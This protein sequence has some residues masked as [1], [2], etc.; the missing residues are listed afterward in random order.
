MVFLFFF[1]NFYS[2]YIKFIDSSYLFPPTSC[3]NLFLFCIFGFCFC[4]QLP[5]I[6]DTI[7]YLFLS[8]WLILFG[9]T[10]LML[11]K[12]EVQEGAL[13]QHGLQNFDHFCGFGCH[14]S[15]H[16]VKKSVHKAVLQV[17]Q[18]SDETPEGINRSSSEF[19]HHRLTPELLPGPEVGKVMNWRSSRFLRKVIHLYN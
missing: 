14:E 13:P 8:V 12:G 1:F 3:N 18:I 17:G 15:G 19:I 7:Q 9:I 11:W 6:R 5:S 16:E 2:V 4:F 10:P